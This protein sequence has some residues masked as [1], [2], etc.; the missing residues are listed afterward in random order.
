MHS[1]KDNRIVSSLIEEPSL[2]YQK[3]GF[4][5]I[6]RFTAQAWKGN[7]WRTHQNFMQANTLLLNLL[8]AQQPLY[9]ARSPTGCEAVFTDAPVLIQTALIIQA[10]IHERSIPATI[11]LYKDQ[12]HLEPEV[13]ISSK[14]REAECLAFWGLEHEILIMPSVKEDLEIPIGVGMLP[15]AKFIQKRFHMQLWTLHVYQD[16]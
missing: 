9:I 8:D 16:E 14:E 6:I 1:P 5:L 4:G 13:W 3:L 12:G 2:Q 7:H 11:V 10:C 15:A